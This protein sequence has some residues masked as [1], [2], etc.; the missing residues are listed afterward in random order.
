M[1]RLCVVSSSVHTVQG[2]IET[3]GLRAG[4]LGR[5]LQ[6]HAD[7]QDRAWAAEHFTAHPWDSTAADF[8]HQLT[9]DNIDEVLY[10][11]SRLLH[12][13]PL[14]AEVNGRP[15]VDAVYTCANPALEMTAIGFREVIAIA[16]DPGPVYRDLFHSA[17]IPEMAWRSRIRI[18]R[19]QRDPKSLGVEETVAS[20]QG[21]INLYD[22][23]LDQGIKFLTEHIEATP[24]PDPRWNWP[25]RQEPV[26]EPIGEETTPASDRETEAEPEPSQS[27][28]EDAPVAD[29]SGDQ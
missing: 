27:P 23:G 1:S 17:V 25:K 16:P 14:P 26:R 11:A 28:L 8:A 9:A 20:E 29:L 10:A 3:Q 21:L 13:C 4:A 6:V 15:A 22:H 24:P 2:A 18:I 7:R 12:A 19:P 5:R